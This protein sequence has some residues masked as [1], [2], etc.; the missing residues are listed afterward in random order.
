MAKRKAA[1]PDKAIPL[2][3]YAELMPWIE[4]FKDGKFNCLTI[5]SAPGLLKSRTIAELVGRVADRSIRRPHF[6]LD[7][8]GKA[9][10]RECQ[11]WL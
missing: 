3:T 11:P 8:R 6:R 10:C 9:T 5:L 4:K 1:I 7:R 2:T